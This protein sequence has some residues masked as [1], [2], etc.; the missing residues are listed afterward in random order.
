MGL[1]WRLHYDEAEINLHCS[2]RNRSGGSRLIAITKFSKGWKLLDEA[3][4]GA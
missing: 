1:S 2:K 4:E 3:V